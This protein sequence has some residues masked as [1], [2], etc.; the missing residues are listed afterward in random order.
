[1]SYAFF[2]YH[3]QRGEDERGGADATYDDT[4]ST[5]LGHT[6]QPFPPYQLQI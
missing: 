6:R 1:M 5:V 3:T 4:I 2:L